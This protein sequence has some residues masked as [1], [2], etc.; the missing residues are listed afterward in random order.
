MGQQQG[1]ATILELEKQGLAELRLPAEP[2]LDPFIGGVIQDGF[3]LVALVGQVGE[4]L[5]VEV[6]NGIEWH[7]VLL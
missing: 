3:V 7:G 6:V 4:Q 2:G 1:E 5:T